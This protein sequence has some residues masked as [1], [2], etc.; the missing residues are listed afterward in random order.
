[1]FDTFALGLSIQ[2]H[3]GSNSKNDGEALLFHCTSFRWF[4][5]APIEFQCLV[6]C[7]LEMHGCLI[8]RQSLCQELF[9][10]ACWPSGVASISH[11]I[12]GSAVKEGSSESSLALSWSINPLT[13]IAVK[14]EIAIL[15]SMWDNRKLCNCSAIFVACY[16]IV[17]TTM[18]F[19]P[20]RVFAS[21]TL[22]NDII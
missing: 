9:L 14:N 3:F 7:E 13:A 17:M 1:M 22:K 16:K 19:W 6:W 2:G 12:H 10:F 21:H 20:I 15:M 18:H 8:H 4:L 5:L 11:T